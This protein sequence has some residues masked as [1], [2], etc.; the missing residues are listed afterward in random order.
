ME[1]WILGVW[2]GL[3]RWG[4]RYQPRIPRE[5]TERRMLVLKRIERIVDGDDDEDREAG[6]FAAGRRGVVGD[7][8]VVTS[9]S[10]AE[11]EDAKL[12]SS[13]SFAVSL[14]RHK[15]GSSSPALPPKHPR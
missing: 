6:F 5:Q 8:C 10:F 11:T 9:T 4:V 15:S 3:G 12:R 2:V 7:K 1:K 13:T 14:S